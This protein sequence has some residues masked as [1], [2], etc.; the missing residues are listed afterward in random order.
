MTQTGRTLEK[1]IVLN[2]KTPEHLKL[3]YRYGISMH[4]FDNNEKVGHWKNFIHSFENDFAA[5][6]RFRLITKDLNTAM[7][8][9]PGASCASSLFGTVY[10]T[11]NGTEVVTRLI[12]KKTS[13][14]ITVQDAFSCKSDLAYIGNRLSEKFH[15]KFPLAT[16]TI[17]ATGGFFSAGAFKAA[18]DKYD[19]RDTPEARITSDWPLLVYRGKRGGPT[20]VIA[21]RCIKGKCSRP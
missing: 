13:R 15:R 18:M 6:R 20:Q 7:A 4:P 5:N 8:G 16:G 19:A 9:S 12:D 11:G 14:I 1:K 21:T 17:T 2:R 10:Q 3:S